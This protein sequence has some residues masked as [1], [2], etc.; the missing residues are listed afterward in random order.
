[1]LY[2]KL[3]KKEKKM[4][5]FEKIQKVMCA[6]RSIINGVECCMLFLVKSFHF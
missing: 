3:N 6:K 1:M 4:S 2:P 5:F